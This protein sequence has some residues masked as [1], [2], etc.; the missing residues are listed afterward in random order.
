M[1]RVNGDGL[2]DEACHVVAR[3]VREEIARRRVSRQRLADE[4]RVSISTLEKALSGR[5]PF[6]LATVIRLEEALGLALRPE[7]G[8]ATGATGVSHGNGLA[9]DDLGNYARPGVAFLEG[10]YLTLRPSFG[11]RAAVYA[12]RTEIAWDGEAGRLAFRESERIDT[13]FTQWG[14]VSVPSQSG[15]IYLITNRHGQY[16]LAI[17]SRPTINGEMHGVLATLQ[18]GRGAQLTPVASPLVLL[19]I[20]KA[21]EVHFG[22]IDPRHQAYARYKALLK[23]TLDE[24]FVHFMHM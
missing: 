9:P 3:R 1:S 15:H 10:S 22:R 4:A 12:F 19:P 6:T 23:R 8:G 5:R 14:T 16:R 11:D 24:P 17:L 7:N 21:G 18:A 20:K 13:E 2:S